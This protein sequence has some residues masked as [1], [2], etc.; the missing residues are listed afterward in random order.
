VR[1]SAE[2]ELKLL[3]R[4][5]D[6]ARVMEALRTMGRELAH[7]TRSAATAREKIAAVNRYFY[8]E[9]G[10]L[11]E[12]DTSRPENFCLTSVVKKRR[13]SCVG[14]AMLCLAATE[15]LGLPLYAVL[16]PGHAFVRWQDQACT[17]NIETLRRGIER[18]DQFY[19]QEFKV[20]PDDPLYLKNIDREKAA[21]LLY[22]NIGNTYRERQRYDEAAQA[23]TP[24]VT[25]LPE[26][27]EARVNLG[28]AYQML[29]KTEQA[30]QERQEAQ[31]LRPSLE[32]AGGE[33]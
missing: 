6:T 7:R 23:Y 5:P 9:M 1:I 32:R 2:A 27:M 3:G 17:L 22:F 20:P 16:L 19:R 12:P 11:P 4:E 14:M 25:L 30:Q 33:K 10:Y 18:T 15:T 21:A 29:G 28:N 31:R 13:A 26:F 8:D 24:A